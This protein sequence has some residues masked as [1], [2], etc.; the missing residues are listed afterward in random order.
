MYC[1]YSITTWFVVLQPLTLVSNFQTEL[2]NQRTA[3]NE[4][5][6][7]PSEFLGFSN[8]DLISNWYPNPIH[9]KDFR[10]LCKYCN[11]ASLNYYQRLQNHEDDCFFSF[12]LIVSH[13]L[14]FVL[15]TFAEVISFYTKLD[16]LTLLMITEMIWG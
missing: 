11:R 10:Y 12:I 2:I 9:N 6:S 3:E 5:I 8:V 16:K 14:T 1:G 15:L 13:I 7:S 4:W